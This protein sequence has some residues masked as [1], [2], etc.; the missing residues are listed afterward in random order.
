MAYFTP[1]GFK[2]VNGE[3]E[4]TM[5]NHVFISARASALE[6]DVNRVRV[7]RATSASELLDLF[8]ANGITTKDDIYKSSSVDFC[9]EVGWVA[10]GAHRVIDRAMAMLVV[11]TKDLA[12][13]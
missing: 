11:A 1:P 5:I 12:N 3:W 2:K 9:E 8:I 10:G 7:G 6:V 4:R 13:Q